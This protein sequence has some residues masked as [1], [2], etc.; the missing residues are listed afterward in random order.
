MTLVT[1]VEHEA[2]NPKSETSGRG[3]D[4]SVLQLDGPSS[5]ERVHV[6]IGGKAKRIPKSHRRLN[7]QLSLQGEATLPCGGGKVEPG[8][9][10]SAKM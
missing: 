7:T 5:L 10:D 1:L 3:A 4:A 6:A 9:V 8:N 2:L